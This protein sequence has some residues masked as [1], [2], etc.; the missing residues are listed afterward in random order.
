MS[1]TT[2]KRIMLFLLGCVPVRLLFVYLA[3]T[4]YKHALA[5]A[6]TIPTLGF[7]YL[8]V[9]DTRNTGPETFGQPIWWKD[10]RIFHAALYIWYI[11]SAFRE[12]TDAYIPLALDVALGVVAFVHHHTQNTNR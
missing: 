6:L 8:Y 11:Q 7:I 12:C 10:L 4:K 1:G 2:T 5:Y 3:T 9:T